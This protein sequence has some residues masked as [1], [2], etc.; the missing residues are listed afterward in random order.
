M[1]VVHNI[2]FIFRYK[3][4]Q[5]KHFKTSCRAEYKSHQLVLLWCNTVTLWS[6]SATA[7]DHPGPLKE[8]L[9]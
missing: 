6:R 3:R 5:S 9:E 8:T 4:L 2:P 7:K 1:N